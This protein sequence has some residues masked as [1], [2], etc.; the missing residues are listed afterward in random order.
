MAKIHG[1]VYVLVGL[2]VSIFSWK[3]N[4]EKF[5]FFFYF[6]WVFVFIGIVKPIFGFVNRKINKKEKPKE[7]GPD[8]TA[9]QPQ[10]QAHHYKRC[11]KCG[12]IVKINGPKYGF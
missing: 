1:L 4:Y 9:I 3:V 12:N 7:R 6:G 8:K 5:I 10:Q 2:F 11:H